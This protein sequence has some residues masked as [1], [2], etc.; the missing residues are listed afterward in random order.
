LAVIKEYELAQ[1]PARENSVQVSPVV[2]KV[3]GSVLDQKDELVTA[4]T[5]LWRSG[6][7]PVLVHGGG[8]V[9]NGWLQRLGI[10]PHF[11]D[12]RRVTD[13]ATLEIVRTVMIGQINS[14]LVRSFAAQGVP[15]VGLNGLDAGMIRARRAPKQLGMVGYVEEVDAYLLR[16][17]CLGGFL[18]VIA[19]LST[20][21]G[22]ECLNVNADDAATAI[23]CSLAAEALVFL[24]NVPGVRGVQGD[25]IPSLTP[26]EIDNLIATGVITGGMIPKV[27][28]C[29][30]A[31]DYVQAVHI[32]DGSQS[33]NLMDTLAGDQASGTRITR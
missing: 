1:A 25:I 4:I 23:A 3:G 29:V 17:L 11:I 28:S 20:G 22:G 30:H 14:E 26:R 21:P 31:L 33:H 10:E 5:A 15:A 32:V 12:G 7:Q 6:R 27:E 9:I 2:I 8:P 16:S 19:P 24:S 18:P 13:D